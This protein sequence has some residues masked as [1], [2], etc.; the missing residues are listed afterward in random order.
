[1]SLIG[2]Y[3][4]LSCLN[5]ANINSYILLIFGQWIGHTNM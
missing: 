3:Y 5:N 4:K 2:Y 1:M